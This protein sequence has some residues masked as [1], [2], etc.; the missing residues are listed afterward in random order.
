MEGVGLAVSRSVDALGLAGD[1]FHIEVEGHQRLPVHHNEL[2][3]GHKRCAL[4]VVVIALGTV[5]DTQ[6]TRNGVT[7]CRGG[8][9]SRLGG[10][11]SGGLSWGGS[12][13]LSRGGGGGSR[14]GGGGSLGGR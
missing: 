8:R 14:R 11:G 6:N 3:F 10:R 2:N 1:R 12:G 5:V 4:R 9:G 7:G 13:S